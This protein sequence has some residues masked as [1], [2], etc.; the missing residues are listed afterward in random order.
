V[1]SVFGNQRPEVI[2]GCRNLR[3]DDFRSIV[4]K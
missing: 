1:K 4:C 2:R 3:K